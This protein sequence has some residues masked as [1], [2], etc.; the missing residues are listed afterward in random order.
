MRRDIAARGTVEAL[1]ALTAL[2]LLLSNGCA[3]PSE[4]ARRSPG[5]TSDAPL[6][7]LANVKNFQEVRASAG[8][9][10]EVVHEISR[11]KAGEGVGWRV[12]GRPDG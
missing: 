2:A 10:Y 11:G 7:L 1:F 5:E 8:K 9:H 12:A 4:Q 3:S 6:R